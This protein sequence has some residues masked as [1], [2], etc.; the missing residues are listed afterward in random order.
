MKKIF[1]SVCTI[2]LSFGAFAQQKLVPIDTIVTQQ[3]VQ[4][5]K[6]YLMKDGK[7]YSVEEGVKTELTRNVTLRNGTVVS[8]TGE[9]RTA[10]GST[11]KL[12][13]G[14]YADK[15]GKIGE[16]KDQMKK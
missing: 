4:D 16:W 15:D 3:K 14:Q 9:V 5:Q 2:A 13:D 11:V 6:V 1:L 12:I 8:T 10:D 7:M